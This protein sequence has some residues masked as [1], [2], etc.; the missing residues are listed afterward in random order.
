[1]EDLR[2]ESAVRRSHADIRKLLI[3]IN[4]HDILASTSALSGWLKAKAAAAQAL[5]TGLAAR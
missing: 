5:A 2:R 3:I 1:M 4:L